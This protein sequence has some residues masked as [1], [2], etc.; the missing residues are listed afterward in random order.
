MQPQQ[1]PPQPTEPIVK[2]PFPKWFIVLTTLGPPEISIDKFLIRVMGNATALTLSGVLG[3]LFLGI[4]VG[5]AAAD[6]QFRSVVI[7]G[8]I[9]YLATLVMVG[10]S[11]LV[12][13]VCL[14]SGYRSQVSIKTRFT[15]L[16]IIGNVFW[17]V[18]TSFLFLPMAMS[19]LGA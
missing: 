11:V 2:L 7:F 17:L 5:E 13:K 15:A 9:F 19:V 6:E 12:A 14:S 4:A 3:T 18:V 10:L 1:Q 8:I 16:V